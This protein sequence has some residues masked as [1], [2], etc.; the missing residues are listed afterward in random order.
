MREDVASAFRRC[1]RDSSLLLPLLLLLS[2]WLAEWWKSGWEAAW[3]RRNS[4]RRARTSMS[5]GPDGGGP[6]GRVM[7]KRA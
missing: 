1:S 4:R 2:N 7:G 5:K 3:R 6:R